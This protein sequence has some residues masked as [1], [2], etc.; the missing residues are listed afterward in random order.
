MMYQ[1][2]HIQK[3]DHSRISQAVPPEIVYDRGGVHDG[4]LGMFAD[5]EEMSVSSSAGPV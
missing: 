1:Y 4:I 5:I 3:K 2:D